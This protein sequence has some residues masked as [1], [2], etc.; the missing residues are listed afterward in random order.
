MALNEQQ[1]AEKKAANAVK[2]SA[3]SERCRLLRD[4]I[5][6]AEA[7]ADVLAAKSEFEAMRFA[8]EDA[9]AKKERRLQ[10]LREMIKAIERQIEEVQNE[11]SVFDARDAEKAAWA[12]WSAL[13]T[14]KVSAAEAA[15]PD[16]AGDARWS[17]AVWAPPPEVQKA[18][19]AA[20]AA[21]H[22]A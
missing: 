6:T 10:D 15:F 9:R 3:H 8:S 14:A 11:R 19:D 12:R 2:R 18:M 20:R 17:S 1:R 7:A 22:A 4:A 16:L 21:V 13:R 5:A